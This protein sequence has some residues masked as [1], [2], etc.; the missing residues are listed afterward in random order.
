M[1]MNDL[2]KPKS[3]NKE[4]IYRN[5]ISIYYYLLF[6]VKPNDYYKKIIKYFYKQKTTLFQEFFYENFLLNQNIFFFTLY[7]QLPVEFLPLPKKYYYLCFPL[8][9]FMSNTTVNYLYNPITLNKKYINNNVID[10]NLYWK[11]YNENEMKPEEIKKIKENIPNIKTGTI[12]DPYDNFQICF[13]M[14]YLNKLS[15]F[16]FIKKSIMIFTDRPIISGYFTK[17]NNE[18]ILHNYYIKNN[19]VKYEEKTDNKIINI[20]SIKF[21]SVYLPFNNNDVIKCFNMNVLPK[22]TYLYNQINVDYVDKIKNNI[23][24]YFTLTPFV[25]IQD[26]LHLLPSN[27]YLHSEFIT[28]D[29]IKLLNLTTTIYFN[30]K[31]VNKNYLIDSNDLFYCFNNYSNLKHCNYDLIDGNK[32]NTEVNYNKKLNL[33]III[34]KNKK[35][36]DH[37]MS[38][39]Y[40]LK[41]LKINS[42]FNMMSFIELKNNKI[43][44]LGEEIY[45]SALENIKPNTISLINNYTDDITNFHLY[46]E[47]NKYE[48]IYYNP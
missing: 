8:I 48:N 2:Y 19:N 33:F 22:N 41:I 28:N 15:N 18:F 38:Y 20:E 16:W 5:F 40:F 17:K 47:K 24:E 39:N 3:L 4:E 25:R 21:I 12:E 23:P 32:I 9:T 44:Q 13:N 42:F 14:D 46:N 43:K 6:N 29:N 30:N 45:I 36:I 31:L 1:K 26:P 27:K 7:N 34:W 37:F 35:F 10:I 11:K